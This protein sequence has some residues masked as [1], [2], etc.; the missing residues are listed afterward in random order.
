ML[1]CVQMGEVF[2]TSSEEIVRDYL[3]PEGLH[4]LLAACLSAP[5]GTNRPV[6]AYSRAPIGKIELVELMARELGLEFR[7]T[8]G[9][10][11]INATGIKPHYYSLNRSA[12]DLGYDPLFTSAEAILKEARILLGC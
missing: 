10:Q 7:L 6:D 5:M 12:S 4:A 2:E 3:E 9:L 11:G 1:R 8:S